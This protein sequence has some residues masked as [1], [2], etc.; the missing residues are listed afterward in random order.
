MHIDLM[1]QCVK[2]LESHI[3]IKLTIRQV[4]DK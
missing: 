2:V 4:L 1:E 3:Q